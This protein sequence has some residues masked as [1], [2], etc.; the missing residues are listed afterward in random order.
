MNA[1]IK[2]KHANHDMFC[3]IAEALKVIVKNQDEKTH[4]FEVDIQGVKGVGRQFKRGL[5]QRDNSASNLLPAYA[6]LR[7]ELEVA[8][9]A[10]QAGLAGRSDQRIASIEARMA[11]MDEREAKMAACIEEL[12]G[13]RPQW[14]LEVVRVSSEWPTPL[15]RCS[16]AASASSRWPW[17]LQRPRPGP[18]P[19]RGSR[20]ASASCRRTTTS[21][22]H[23]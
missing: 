2:Q 22:A 9:G 4:D 11:T 12:D 18:L 7:D 21:C 16:S 17:R 1:W 14:G 3:K 19:T 15:A 10:F 23:L 20:P 8:I 6:A 5:F 13:A